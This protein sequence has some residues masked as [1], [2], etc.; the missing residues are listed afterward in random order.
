MKRKFDVQPLVGPIP[1]RFGMSEEQVVELLGQPRIKDINI[2]KEPDWDY[3]DFSVRFGLCGEGVVEVGFLP[4]AELT[5]YGIDL[6]GEPLAFK[7]IISNRA[8]VFEHYGFIIIP[9]LGLTFTGFHDDS[10]ADKAITAFASGRW[11]DLKSEFVP[12]SSHVEN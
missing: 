12:F 11:D 4:E 2:R 6:F 3:E 7:K 9:S 1:I 8:D 10:E 5:L